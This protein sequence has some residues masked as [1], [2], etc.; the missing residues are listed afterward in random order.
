MESSRLDPAMPE[1]HYV[2]AQ[3][4]MKQGRKD[5]AQVQMEQYKNKKKRTGATL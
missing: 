2:M 5:L 4:L 3:V 1:P